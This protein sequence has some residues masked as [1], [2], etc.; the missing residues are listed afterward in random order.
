MEQYVDSLRH[1]GVTF[2]RWLLRLTLLVTLILFLSPRLSAESLP[3]GTPAYEFTRYNVTYKW[4]FDHSEKHLGN[5]YYYYNVCAVPASTDIT[6]ASVYLHWYNDAP[7]APDDWRGN[8]TVF[9]EEEWSKC[10]NLKS[11][12]LITNNT[13]SEFDLF[14]LG[15][16]S[17]LSALIITDKPNSSVQEFFNVPAGVEV[18]AEYVSKI[19]GISNVQ[20]ISAL[21]DKLFGMGDIPLALNL[22]N[23]GKYGLTPSLKISTCYPNDVY[24][25]NYETTTYE[26]R[27]DDL[28][29]PQIPFSFVGPV[30][31]EFG[32]PQ[33][34]ECDREW[35]WTETNSRI[36]ID[37]KTLFEFEKKDGYEILKPNLSK[38]KECGFSGCKIWSKKSDSNY[39]SYTIPEENECFYLPNLATT[40]YPGEYYIEFLSDDF[41]QF[42]VY[43]QDQSHDLKIEPDEWTP[44]SAKFRLIHNLPIPDSDVAYGVAEVIDNEIV[45]FVPFENDIAYLEDFDKEFD[46]D[47]NGSTWNWKN[48][49][50]CYFYAK[51]NDRYIRLSDDCYREQYSDDYDSF[52]R[53]YASLSMNLYSNKMA[54][55]PDGFSFGLLWSE[56]G[57][58]DN[59]AKKEGS[60]YSS[61]YVYGYVDISD[62]LPGHGYKMK[63]YLEINGQQYTSN[64]F[65]VYTKGIATELIA[66]NISTQSVTI[67][68]QLKKGEYV[69]KSNGRIDYSDIV[70]T[71]GE[72]TY[73]PE[74]TTDDATFHFSGLLA[75]TKFKVTCNPYY[76]RKS[77]GKRVELGT[78]TYEVSGVEGYTARPVWA[79]G[80]AEALTTTK[81]RLKYS[82]NLESTIDSYIEWRRVDAPD[83]VKSQ[84]ALCPVVDGILI[85]VLKNL[86]PDVYYQYRPVYPQGNLQ[87]IGEWVG[88]FTGDANV[89]FDPEVGTAP[90]RVRTDGSVTLSGSVLPGSG[91]VNEQGFELWSAPDETPARHR[92]P[93]DRRV[94][95]C[96]G[97]S[98]SVDLTDLEGGEYVYRTFAI[99]DGTSFFGDEQKF[100]IQGKGGVEGVTV[101]AVAP[102]IV[103][104]YNLQGVFSETPHQGLNIVVYSNG[105]TEK[106]VIRSL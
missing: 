103:G 91:D 53:N 70:L 56:S 58:F 67:K 104:Y 45:Q 76:E 30:N 11:L 71:M 13:K 35:E 38:F 73:E 60:I 31:C 63:L 39:L 99:V 28:G 62:L 9:P 93:A 59:A 52:Y 79:D 43:N 23:C 92:A 7:Y 22:E 46:I 57:D 77:D 88:I 17:S 50:Q 25:T 82:T 36:L 48:D 24:A 86:N 2:P 47:S 32:L 18:Y 3:E 41:N 16:C 69:S 8:S 81:A 51:I 14:G 21:K 84:T 78:V 94:I 27:Y 55:L 12:E 33:L 29:L 10:A 37:W 95:P 6:F 61:G 74:E 4:Y 49:M 19:S 72:T 64:L 26:V 97:I 105:K 5:T 83:V 80:T 65:T 98:L 40:Y 100:T 44:Y 96:D 1:R 89:W 54:K 20:P 75:N 68:C 85:G 101:D 87:Y 106:C 15:G 66:S 90:A 34:V 102:E 42:C